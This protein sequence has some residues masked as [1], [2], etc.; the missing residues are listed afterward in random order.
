M[1]AAKEMLETSDRTAEAIALEV[2]Y[3][4]VGFAARRH[5]GLNTMVLKRCVPRVHIFHTCTHGP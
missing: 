2:G 1:E 3:Q 5:G 4:D